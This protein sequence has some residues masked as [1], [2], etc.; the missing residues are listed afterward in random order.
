MSEFEEVG[1]DTLVEVGVETLDDVDTD[2]D[3]DTELDVDT[4]ETRWG[5]LLHDKKSSC[6]FFVSKESCYYLDEVDT[7]D[8]VDTDDEV[9]TELEVDT[10]KKKERYVRYKQL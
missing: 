4:L 3:V 7:L 2:D 6:S 9:D 1:V 10:L 5:L 8:D